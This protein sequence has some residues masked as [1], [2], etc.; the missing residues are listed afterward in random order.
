ML[1]LALIAS[2]IAASYAAPCTEEQQK[3]A[4][5]CVLKVLADNP[6]CAMINSSCGLPQAADQCDCASK[7]AAC[8]PTD[9]EPPT[10]APVPA[11]TAT[12]D[13]ACVQKC[14]DECGSGPCSDASVVGV[15]AVA[16][17]AAVAA[18]FF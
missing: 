7:I 14:I 12:L 9:C 13:P 1:S 18:R 8:A 16:I 4:T 15:S 6:P 5:D 3:E 17:V 10:S 11:S 2:L